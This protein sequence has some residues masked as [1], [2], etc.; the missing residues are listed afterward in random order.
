[1]HGLQLAF[2]YLRIGI[3]NEFQYRANLYIQVLQTFIA[4]ATGL[5]GLNLVFSQTTDLGG[6]N[7]AELLAVMGVFTIT[8]L[9]GQWTRFGLIDYFLGYL[10]L[11]GSMLA[12]PLGFM[13]EVRREQPDVSP[14]RNTHFLPI[15]R[16]ILL[17][18]NTLAEV[19]PHVWPMLLFLVAV[20]AL[21]LRRYR[22]TLD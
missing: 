11:F 16:G 7:K 21:G 8:Y 3:M 5:I 1:M 15:V 4:L 9:N 20:L 6:W 10:S 13:A 22:Q 2:N 17:K 19:A 12:R 14:K 18:G